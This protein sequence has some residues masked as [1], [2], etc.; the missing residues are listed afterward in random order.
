VLTRSPRGVHHRWGSE[1]DADDQA[2]QQGGFREPAEAALGDAL[3]HLLDGEWTRWIVI[4]VLALL[5]VATV[6]LIWV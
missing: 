5:V 6:V 1:G 4:R 2:G 3:G